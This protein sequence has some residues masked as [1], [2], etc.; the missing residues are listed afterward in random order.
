[1]TDQ[2]I[3]EKISN[4]I[5]KIIKRPLDNLNMFIKISTGLFII[6][7]TVTVM[8]YYY[9]KN[10]DS[11]NDEQIELINDNN[12]QLAKIIDQNYFTTYNVYKEMQT[13]LDTLLE[14]SI[15]IQKQTHAL[16]Q[17]YEKKSNCILPTTEK[18]K[19][20]HPFF[21]DLNSRSKPH[22]QEV[23][24]RQNP[25]FEDCYPSSTKE[26]KEVVHEG[27]GTVLRVSGKRFFS[28]S[29]EREVALLLFSLLLRL[30]HA[31]LFLLFC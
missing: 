25:T 20:T 24:F 31:S 8:N 6:T 3:S 18:G 17:K 29:K 28:S 26:Y 22:P 16:L 23:N 12:V 15:E 21:R 10:L 11:K 1:M 30:A 27:T 4:V 14:I 9:I 19:K 7:T 13:K 5:T 2:N